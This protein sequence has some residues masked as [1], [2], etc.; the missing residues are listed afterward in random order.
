MLCDGFGLWHKHGVSMAR[1]SR[2]PRPAL[3]LQSLNE[4][5]L[6]YVARFAT[7]RAKLATY[8]NRK[9]RERG[10]E[11]EASPPIADIVEKLSG[12]GYVDDA[13]FALSKARSLGARGFG[14]RRVRSALREAGI[15][16]QDGSAA[17]KEAEDGKVA[18][19]IKFAQRRR[20]GPFASGEVDRAQREKWIAAMVRA[21][22]GFD[23]ARKICDLPPGREPDADMLLD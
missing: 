7:S 4:L 14:E 3:D 8:L 2:K 17:L 6:S 11:D 9:V 1:K 23:V 22:H 19:A 21:G 18:S 10:W 5:A 13:Q 16:E 12:Y 20:F 15:D